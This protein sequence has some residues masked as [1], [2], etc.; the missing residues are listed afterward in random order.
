LI[1]D[2]DDDFPAMQLEPKQ[3]LPMLTLREIKTQKL[4]ENCSNLVEKWTKMVDFSRCRPN[5]V[6]NWLKRVQFFQYLESFCNDDGRENFQHLYSYTLFIIFHIGAPL[7][8][9]FQ[10]LTRRRKWG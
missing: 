3:D 4:G 6:E 1:D 5:M 2:D 10:G 8:L 7:F 9:Q